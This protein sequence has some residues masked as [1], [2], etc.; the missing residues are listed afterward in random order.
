VFDVIERENFPKE[1]LFY[2]SLNFAYRNLIIEEENKRF[3]VLEDKDRI[4]FGFVCNVL[5]NYN[6][7]SS[8]LDMMDVFVKGIDEVTIDILIALD[9]PE[10]TKRICDILKKEMGLFDLKLGIFVG[11]DFTYKETEENFE[12]LMKLGVSKLI[13]NDVMNAIKFK[14][15]VNE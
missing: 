2:S 14:N 6:G 9:F 10:E 12:K 5:D 1:R 15:A 11:F 7:L 3:G 13:V 4:G 8:V